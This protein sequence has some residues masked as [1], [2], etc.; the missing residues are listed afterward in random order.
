[1]GLHGHARVLE[2]GIDCERDAVERPDRRADNEVRTD[3]ALEQ[4]QERA[5]LGC[6]AIAT[7]TKHERDHGSNPSSRYAAI[8]AEFR[9]QEPGVHTPSECPKIPLRPAQ[10]F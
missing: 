6:P 8:T 4:R 9:S 7:T 1:P 10:S 2:R 5:G 3:V